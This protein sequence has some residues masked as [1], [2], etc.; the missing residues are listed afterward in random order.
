MDALME[1]EWDTTSYD[2]LVLQ[3]QVDWEVSR[4]AF[5]AT[6]TPIAR[7][8]KAQADFDSNKDVMYQEYRDY[9]YERC[10]F[11]KE[12]HNK[13][14][15]IIDPA[16]LAAKGVDIDRMV[17]RGDQYDPQ[18]EFTEVDIYDRVNKRKVK[19]NDGLNKIKPRTNQEI[20]DAQGQQGAG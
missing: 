7:R 16:D 18:P 9:Q 1:Q 11:P 13:R 4:L 15:Y 14:R 2:P 6:L 20:D 19:K 8:D 5:I 17:D 3:T 10:K 12:Y